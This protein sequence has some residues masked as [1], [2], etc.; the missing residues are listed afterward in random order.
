MATERR[1]KKLRADSAHRLGGAR[2]AIDRPPKSHDRIQRFLGMIRLLAGGQVWRA[3]QLSAE[4]EVTERT[5]LRDMKVLEDAG[6][7]VRPGSRH[8]SGYRLARQAAWESPQMSLGEL[9]AMVT[10]IGRA[11]VDDADELAIVRE[12]VLKLIRMQPDDV[13]TQ[14]ESLLTQFETQ[15]ITARAWLCRQ[16]WLPRLVQ[17]LVH[18]TPLRVWL[19]TPR[20]TNA[21]PLVIV[22]SAIAA[23]DGA[24]LLCGYEVSGSDIMV[25]LE[26]VAMIERDVQ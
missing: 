16:T 19:S 24:W 20:E 21:A 14:L 1:S 18:H 17:A 2:R 25:A 5:I 12:A 7:V 8:R 6:L 3:R 26:E 22:P 10:L 23:H 9:L 11:A 4:F 15:D 13:R